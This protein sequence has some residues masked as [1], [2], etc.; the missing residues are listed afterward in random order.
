MPAFTRMRAREIIPRIRPLALK[1]LELDR[2]L[3]EPHIDLA[4]VSFL[5]YDWAGAESEF[6]KGLELSPGN[7][8]A[9]RWYAVYLFKV[10]RLQEALAES[11][12]SQQLDPVSPYMLDG[13]ARS[14]YMLRRYDEA[15]EQFKETLALDSQHGRAH[16]GL[17]LTYMQKHMYPDAIAEFQVAREQMRNSPAPAGDLAYAYA[18]SGN[19]SEAQRILNEFLGQA[20]RGTFPPEPIAD[21]YIGL[22][23]KDRAFEWLNKAINAQDV[24][25]YLKADP[26]YDPLRSD[27]RFAQLLDRARLP[28]L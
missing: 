11:V 14:L 22:G 17:G 16:L 8:V 18:V 26:I 27:P 28:R 25:L 24:N 10:G 1:A 2:S 20:A 6:K 19:V 9:H 7:A 15:I 23:D 4:Y 13:T 12:T 21:V 5:N 3:A